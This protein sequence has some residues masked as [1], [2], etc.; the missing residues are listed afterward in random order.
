MTV[1]KS[2]RDD[3]GKEALGMTLPPHPEEPSGPEERTDKGGI[4]S[5]F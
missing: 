5:L 2:A 4:G 3:T 1:K